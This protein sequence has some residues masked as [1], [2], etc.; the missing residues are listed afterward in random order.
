MSDNPTDTLVSAKFLEKFHTTL[1]LVCAISGSNEAKIL[2]GISSAKS[3]E[4]VTEL[5]IQAA[6]EGPRSEDFG[7]MFEF[8]GMPDESGEPIM[9]RI[10]LHVGSEDGVAFVIFQDEEGVS[11]GASTFG[12]SNVAERPSGMSRETVNEFAGLT[13]IMKRLLHEA[14]TAFPVPVIGDAAIVQSSLIK[15]LDY[16]PVE[17]FLLEREVAYHLLTAFDILDRLRGYDSEDDESF[18]FRWTEYQVFSQEPPRGSFLSERLRELDPELEIEFETDDTQNII[19]EVILS[20]PMPD[21]RVFEV[22]IDMIGVTVDMDFAYF[23]L[24]EDAVFEAKDAG[25]YFRG[26]SPQLRE[27]CIRVLDGLAPFTKGMAETER[28]RARRLVGTTIKAV[29]AA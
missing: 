4:D 8:G 2:Q 19:T 9:D 6:S 16:Q 24:G 10:R 17:T 29:A 11:I 20:Y 5:L 25:Y 12:L 15:L 13:H 14:L 26:T 1:R 7:M 28:L 18:A 23:Q 22:G 27:V 21:G 3:V